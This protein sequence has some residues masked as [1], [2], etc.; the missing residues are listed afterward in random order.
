M[1][2]SSFSILV[3]TATSSPAASSLSSRKAPKLSVDVVL[4]IG[5]GGANVRVRCLEDAQEK[6]NVARRAKKSRQNLHAK[7]ADA[8]CGFR[9]CRVHWC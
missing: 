5:M 6:G 8:K 3:P 4:G 9:D 7:Y 2:D 1:Q